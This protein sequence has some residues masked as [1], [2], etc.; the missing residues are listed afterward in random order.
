MSE[1]AETFWLLFI[2]TIFGVIVGS[3]ISNWLARSDLSEIKRQADSVQQAVQQVVDTVERFD[4]E[5]WKSVVPDVRDETEKAQHEVERL[6]SQIDE[7][8]DSLDSHDDR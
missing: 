1:K 2:G 3:S 5:D 4:S 6:Q 8:R 7:A